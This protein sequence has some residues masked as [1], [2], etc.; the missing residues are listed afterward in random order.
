MSTL[1]KALPLATSVLVTSLGATLVASK[2]FSAA[3]HYV[4]KARP[5]TTTPSEVYSGGSPIDMTN[6]GFF[7]NGTFGQPNP[8]YEKW[9]TSPTWAVN[10]SELA[11]SY[12]DKAKFVKTLNERIQH[13]EHALWN[14]GQVTAVSTPA[15]VA[16][17]QNMTTELTPK[18]D[19]AREAWSKA[20]S[21][22]RSDWEATSGEAK[23]AFLDLQSFSYGLHK[24]VRSAK[25]M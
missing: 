6:G 2:A 19:R 5:A 13:F 7:N 17:A 16:H 22:G 1:S 18:I 4:P 15:G 11:Y 9:G 12:D 20:K 3:G 14:Y 21:S 23:K 24:N 8:T 10:L 25:T